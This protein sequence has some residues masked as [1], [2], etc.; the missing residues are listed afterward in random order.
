[1]K[2]LAACFLAIS[3]LTAAASNAD[4]LGP[5]PAMGP[6][7]DRQPIMGMHGDIDLMSTPHMS[8]ACRTP[9]YY[10]RH[11]SRLGLTGEQ[12]EKMEA[13]YFGLKRDMIEGGAKVKVL[14]LELTEIVIKPDFD[15]NSAL[16]T[17]EKV[18]AA[19]A[20]L[21]AT[22]LKAAAEARDMLTPQ[23]L[24]EARLMPPRGVYPADTDSGTAGGDMEDK[25]RRI[26]EKKMKER[27]GA[28]GN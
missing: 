10:L 26:M 19:R 17:M 6:D 25:A 22:V 27:M 4:A 5:V 9:D 15:L 18:E 14:E 3:M 7:M 12:T 23:Q 2:S 20:K 13:L 24:E 8:K 28:P 11:S 21:R 16:D 1:M